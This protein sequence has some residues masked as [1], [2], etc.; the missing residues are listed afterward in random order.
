MMKKQRVIILLLLLPLLGGCWGSNEIQSLAYVTAIGLDYADGNYKAYVQILNFANVARRES[1]EPGKNIPAWIGRGEGTTVLEAFADL[2]GTSQLRLFWGHV[3]AIVVSESIIKLD[4]LREVADTLN[5]SREIRYN[6]HVY[7]TK[8]NLS[9][10]LSVKSLVNF[11]P[12]ESLLARPIKY[13][14][15]RPYIVPLH[16]FKF[17]A[18][19]NEPG[20]SAYLPSLAIDKRSWSE[21]KRLKPMFRVSGAYFFN[22]K[23]YAGWIS[24]E[25]L[26]GARWFNK[27][28]DI[29][30]VNVPIKGKPTAV[31]NLYGLKYRIQPIVQGSDVTFVISI[32][33]KGNIGGAWIDT[34]DKHLESLA[35][36]GVREEVLATFE[37]C[38]RNKID[39]YRL[40]EQLYR[41]NPNAFKRLMKSKPFP[42][43]HNSLTRVDVHID[44]EHS[45]KYKGKK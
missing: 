26:I 42:L 21:D 10:V 17:L 1:G 28:L 37:T 15:Q 27:R 23:H 38:V 44:I 11:S 14:S 16:G 36:A 22:D 41:D 25:D 31:V 33:L 6:I 32:R 45:G 43:N 40:S 34:H 4:K 29:E 9:D 19:M 7:G 8:E 5:R 12:L 18:A 30:S 3:S 20:Y 35:E 13:Y 24:E 39:V 2:Y